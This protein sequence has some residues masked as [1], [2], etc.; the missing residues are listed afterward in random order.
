VLSKDVTSAV[1]C[2]LAILCLLQAAQRR[3]MLSFSVLIFYYAPR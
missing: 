2:E 3:V 1:R